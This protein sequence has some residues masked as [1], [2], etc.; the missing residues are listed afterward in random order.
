MAACGVFPL[1]HAWPKGVDMK[2]LPM[3][4]KNRKGV[5]PTCMMLMNVTAVAAVRSAVHSTTPRNM[6]WGA[7]RTRVHHE[8][9][10][11][12]AHAEAM[13]HAV[14]HQARHREVVA[15]EEANH[16]QELHGKWSALQRARVAGVCDRLHASGGVRLPRRTV[17][18]SLR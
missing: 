1:R 12:V 3:R 6:A 15:L 2:T 13:L 4:K 5:Y 7:R 18:M 9:G 10:A 16:H 14:R 17:Q 11:Q 8:H